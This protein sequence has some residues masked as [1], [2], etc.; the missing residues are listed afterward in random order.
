MISL[1]KNVFPKELH[2]TICVWNVDT[3]IYP[4]KTWTKPAKEGRKI[5]SFECNAINADEN[6]MVKKV[7]SREILARVIASRKLSLEETYTVKERKIV[8][9]IVRT[10]G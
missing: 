2:P 1:A 6:L 5:D 9:H 4:C 10:R 7:L 8:E 3:H